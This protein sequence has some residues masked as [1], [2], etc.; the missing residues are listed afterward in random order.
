MKAITVTESGKPKEQVPGQIAVSTIPEPALRPTYIKIAPRAVALNPTDWKHIDFISDPGA[1][2]GCDI[3][4][5]VLEVGSGVRTAVAAGDRV[6][7]FAHGGNLSDHATGG[8]GEAAL[9]KD[10]LWVRVPDGMG[11]EDAATL[12]VGVGT[13]GQAL[14]QSLGLPKPGAGKGAASSSA[15]AEK[16]TV[17]IYGGSTATG[18]L[19][20]QFAALSGLRVV[21]T[22]S[23]RNHAMLEGL[24]AAK[25]FDYGDEDCGAKIREYTG[26]K[27]RY[28][29]DCIALPESF[30]ICAAAL[31]ESAEAAGGELHYSAL[32]P[33][34]GFPREDVKTRSTMLYTATNETYTKM[35]RTVTPD[36]K[37]NEEITAWYREAEK[38]IA[39]GK[40]KP[41]AKEVGKG[42]EG[43]IEGLDRMRK[44][45]Y[46]ARKLVYTVA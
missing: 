16:T 31:G 43:V 1:V 25:V 22:A 27:L 37:D 21:T 32:L 20:V 26:G 9:I 24:G 28:V 19:A 14:Y 36:P 38:L 12:P 3:A 30:E 5:V 45:E 8:F 41:H 46:S 2:V 15:A 39:D 34:K 33:P 4:G 10:G 29:F 17:L 44:G 13:V 7:G 6:A 23:A 40:I 35:G 18:T 11:W 42:W